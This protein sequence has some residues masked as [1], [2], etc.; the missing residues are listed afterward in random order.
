MNRNAWFPTSFP[1]DP[2]D[3]FPREDQTQAV[4]FLCNIERH[5]IPESLENPLQSLFHIG[6]NHFKNCWNV[7][8]MLAIYFSS[9]YLEMCL[10]IM[11]DTERVTPK[12]LNQ[13]CK[14]DDEAFEFLIRWYGEF[15]V[16]ILSLC[17]TF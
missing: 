9:D 17:L 12:A 15:L 11:H 1:I 10:C 3:F 8:G 13:I 14:G 5:H 16:D 6:R 7:V 4:C 2:E